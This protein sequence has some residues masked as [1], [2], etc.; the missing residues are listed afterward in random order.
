MVSIM[1]KFLAVVTFLFLSTPTFAVWDFELMNLV[2]YTII[3]NKKIT[4]W[5]D[6]NGKRGDSFEG[7]D[8]NRVIVFDNNKVLTC[9]GYRYHYAYRPTAIILSNG[10]SFK[11]IVGDDVYDMSRS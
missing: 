2:G 4:G 6:N 11:M 10:Y 7:C 3:G 9:R 1:K 8:Y 5:Y